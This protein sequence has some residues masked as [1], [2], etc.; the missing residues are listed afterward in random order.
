MMISLTIGKK[1]YGII[2]LAFALAGIIVAVTFFGLRQ[3]G[4]VMYF[5]SLERDH[6]DLFGQ[7]KLLQK[8]YLL[9]HDKQTGNELIETIDKM[10]ENPAAMLAASPDDSTED[11]ALGRKMSSTVAL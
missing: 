4:D 5:S 7:V 1:I 6:I 3:V 8:E 10:I 11:M 9:S 2:L